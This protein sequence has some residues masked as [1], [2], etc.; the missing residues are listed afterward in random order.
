MEQKD[1][2][3]CS[4][5]KCAARLAAPTSDYNIRAYIVKSRERSG[6]KT[7]LERPARGIPF[8]VCGGSLLLGYRRVRRVL[9]LELTLRVSLERL[10]YA[11]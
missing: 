9:G 6:Q 8:A 11:R 5:L 2:T 7:L 4:L 1:I 10:F 3:P